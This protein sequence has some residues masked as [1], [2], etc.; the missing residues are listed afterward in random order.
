MKITDIVKLLESDSD[1]WRKEY[2]KN[3]L[4]AITTAISK[5]KTIDDAK[6][7]IRWGNFNVKDSEDSWHHPT[8]LEVFK[9]FEGVK[10]AVLEK[11]DEILTDEASYV[12]F[13]KEFTGSPVF[14]LV[15]D[16]NRKVFAEFFFKNLSVKDGI[17]SFGHEQ[18]KNHP[19]DHTI[20][21]I[22]VEEDYDAILEYLKQVVDHIPSAKVS[23]QFDLDGKNAWGIEGRNAIKVS[24][25]GFVPK[26]YRAAMI[27]YVLDTYSGEYDA[28]EVVVKSQAYRGFSRTLQNSI[29]KMTTITEADLYNEEYALFLARTAC[30]EFFSS[31]KDFISLLENTQ[32]VSKDIFAWFYNLPRHGQ[33]HNEKK[34][35]LDTFQEVMSRSG[36]FDLLKT[37]SIFDDGRR[38]SELAFY[39]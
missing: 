6:S 28:K 38:L 33:M 35:F 25:V 22:L 24:E 17:L 8:V 1:S 23:F 4:D 13:V 39:D 9:Q 32:H 14:K 34:K 19:H 5:I 21:S 37:E 29:K 20:L 27:A 11:F 16:R 12:S 26:L 10:E 30:P 2:R 3:L 36:I 31:L 18:I 7:V 15:V